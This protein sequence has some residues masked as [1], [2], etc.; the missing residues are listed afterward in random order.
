[1]ERTLSELCVGVC[2]W[3]YLLLDVPDL[4]TGRAA[5]AGA[6]EGLRPQLRDL[7]T[8]CLSTHT[9]TKL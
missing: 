1:M 2:E 6:H 8:P 5:A 4:H 7:C 9:Q 3:I